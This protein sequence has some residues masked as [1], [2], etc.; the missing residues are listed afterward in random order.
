M[1]IKQ[2]LN[3]LRLELIRNKLAQTNFEAPFIS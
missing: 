1:N 2:L 3:I